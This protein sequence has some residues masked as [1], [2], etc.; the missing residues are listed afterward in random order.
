MKTHKVWFL[1]LLALFLV[2]CNDDD[3]DVASPAT[4]ESVR[5]FSWEDNANGEWV[6]DANGDKVRFEVDT[7]W[8]Y[9][10]STAYTNAK[11]DI[12]DSSEFRLDGIVIGAVVAVKDTEGNTIAALVANDGTY[13]DIQGK[14]EELIVAKTEIPFVAAS[15]SSSVSTSSVNGSSK[16]LR[17]EAVEESN[18]SENFQTSFKSVPLPA[19]N[20]FATSDEPGL[21][22]LTQPQ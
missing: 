11:V 20:A 7:G 12:D 22:I 8:M 6:V 14:E 5:Y 17:F 18:Y 15:V 13:L 21:G 4:G 9:F 2:A 10:G 1:S 3:S 19:S 16:M